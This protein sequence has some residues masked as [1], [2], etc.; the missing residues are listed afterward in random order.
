[1]AEAVVAAT[2]TGAL[3]DEVSRREWFLKHARGLYHYDSTLD[4]Y[5]N[6]FMDEGAK[7]IMTGIAEAVL[8]GAGWGSDDPPNG[9]G[10]GLPWDHTDSLFTTFQIWHAHREWCEDTGSYKSIP[11]KIVY[12]LTRDDRYDFAFQRYVLR[13]EVELKEA[14][15]RWDYVRHNEPTHKWYPYPGVNKEMTK[16]FM[17]LYDYRKYTS[18]LPEDERMGYVF[19][20]N[21]GLLHDD[22]G[23]RTCT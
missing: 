12:Y 7:L 14:V 20:M 17:M 16:K 13:R 19:S 11:N 1:M 22:K 5:T 23:W 6:I 9:K 2:Y 21:G 10:R 18:E 8:N 3:A 15:E 4:P